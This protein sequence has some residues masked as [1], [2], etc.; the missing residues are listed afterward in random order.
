MA[1]APSRLTIPAGPGLPATPPPGPGDRGR[2]L[3]ERERQRRALRA[4]I[5][6]L[7][8]GRSQCVHVVGPPGSGRSAVLADAASAARRGGGT[9]VTARGCLAEARVPFAVAEQLLAGPLGA[10]APG[11]EVPWQA[12]DPAALCARLTGLARTAPLVVIVDDAHLADPGSREVLHLLTVRLHHAPMLLVLGS[13]A[14]WLAGEGEAGGDELALELPPLSQAGLRTALGQLGGG[15]L[16]TDFV[17]RAHA[18]TA[19]NPKLLVAAWTELQDR[20]QQR[21]SAAEFAAAAARSRAAQVEA[22]LDALAPPALELLRLLTVAGGDLDPRLLAGLASGAARRPEALEELRAHGLVTGADRPLPADAVTAERVL[23][24]MGPAER[25]RHYAEVTA[26]AHRSAAPD[27][28]VARLLRASGGAPEP[29][30]RAV[31]ARRAEAAVAVRDDREA[32]ALLGRAAGDWPDAHKDASACIEL[33][34]AEVALRPALS[35]RILV[36][37]TADR[38]ASPPAVRSRLAALDL[39]LLR[40]EAAAARRAAL[41]ALERVAHDPGAAPPAG[42]DEREREYSSLAALAD[43]ATALGPAGAAV[44]ART[45]DLPP[46]PTDPV[47]AGVLALKHAMAGR[48]L[49]RTRH[50]A[51]SA[52]VPGLSE[53]PLLAPRLAACAALTLADDVAEAEAGLAAVLGHAQRRGRRVGAA[54]ACLG[55]AVAA[56]FRGELDAADHHLTRALTELPLSGW[57]PVIRPFPLAYRAWVALERGAVD[58][59]ERALSIPLPEA[60]EDGAAW[61]YLLFARGLVALRRGEHRRALRDLTQ[62]GRGLAHR[63]AVNPVMIPWQAHAAEAAEAL[64]DDATAALLREE[65]FGLSLAWGTA[66]AV[67]TAL[68]TGAAAE[69]SPGAKR[70]GFGRA[71][72]MLRESPA[73]LRHA[74]A[75]RA[76]A[77]LGMVPD[78]YADPGPARRPARRPRRESAGT[79]MRGRPAAQPAQAPRAASRAGAADRSGAGRQGGAASPAGDPRLSPA[80][81]RAVEYAV[82]GLTNAEMAEKLAVTRRTVEYHLT[83]AY[84]KL[85]VTS[86][87]ELATVFALGG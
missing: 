49:E 1:Q 4:A 69:T 13:P 3:V 71:E 54:F 39:L 30:Q 47:G 57:H 45:A 82:A 41:A 7:H 2:P 53:Q 67:G 5:N 35:D 42:A 36:Q 17:R 64:G 44:P 20:Q 50:L 68:L 77:E 60:A 56:R 21:P 26:L 32:A 76:M 78:P 72:R 37:A 59:A 31:L 75:L 12:T 79:R 6:G 43:L 9:V 18:A 86:R 87:A 25:R 85:G 24:L 40:G 27:R 58:Q 74:E 51:K 70:S 38:A 65:S 28:T 10:Q 23:A 46:L 29:W 15:G 84:R 8:G 22:A 80:E 19:G 81:A 55:L 11:E 33:A 61:A 52:L 73:R 16:P 62:A 83:H 66:S 34:C 48:D 14:P 63:R